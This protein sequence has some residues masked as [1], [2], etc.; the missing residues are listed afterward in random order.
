MNTGERIL[1]N[2]NSQKER[3]RQGKF[4]FAKSD[5]PDSYRAEVDD[6]GVIVR[7]EVP[8]FDKLGVMLESAEA[9]ETGASDDPRRFRAQV[10]AVG[11]TDWGLQS[12]FE[13]IERDG[14]TMRAIFR[15]TPQGA[16]PASY[17]ELELSG[18][19]D[20]AVRHFQVEKPGKPRELAPAN[21]GSETFVKLV[22][23]LRG[24]FAAALN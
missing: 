21:L 3:K 7:V 16:E 14:E 11:E 17:F 15:T 22:D 9:R 2:L 1:Q 18:G 8:D 19:K 10:E 12:S 13:L 23:R 24:M 4:D 6:H 5:G 20:A